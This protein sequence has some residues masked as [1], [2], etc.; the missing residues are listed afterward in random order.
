MMYF[1]SRYA[2]LVSHRTAFYEDQ[3]QLSAP[4]SSL[5]CQELVGSYSFTDSQLERFH[6]LHVTMRQCGVAFVVV[7][8]ATISVLMLR[9][10]RPPATCM[11]SSPACMHG[12][13]FRCTYEC[14]YTGQ[15]L[16]HAVQL[17]P[18]YLRTL[19]IAAG[20]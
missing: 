6:R 14:F 20:V 12:Q 18:G 16:L 15:T 5:C 13:Q 1:W 4:G 8:A 19:R 2:V 7:A 10:W 3:E 9:V 17:L 11:C